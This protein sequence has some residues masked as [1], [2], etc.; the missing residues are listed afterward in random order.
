MRFLRSS[1]SGVDGPAPR[2]LGAAWLAGLVLGLGAEWLARPALSL[3]GAA[4]DLT[5]GWTLITCGLVG[6]WRSPRSRV[7]LLLA[8]S[9]FAWFL[10]TLSGSQTRA[11]AAL[12]SALLL[13]HRGPLW[14]AIIGYPS[15]RPGHRL[16]MI[17]VVA[18]YIYA[19]G[20]PAARGDVVTIVVAAAVLAATT[21]GWVMAAG[22]DRRARVTAV[23]AAAALAVP[24]AGGSAWRLMGARPGAD[25]SLL[26]WGYEAAVV[27]I[28]VGFLVELS[29]GRRAQ[30]AVTKLVV[31]L[32]ADTGTGTLR[33]RLAHALG[34]GSLVIVYW[35]PEVSGYVDERGNLVEL[36]EPGSG[37]TVTVVER[38]GEQIAALVHDVAVLDDPALV[39]SVAAAARIALSNVRLRAEVQR[40]VAELDA[41][42]RRIVEAGDAQRRRFQQQLRAGTGQ[43]LAAVGEVL[44]R[45]AWEACT[46]RDRA[47]ADG[48]ISVRNELE[49]A[50]DELRELAAGIH[51]ALLTERGLGAAL[52]SL[53]GRS[54]V[55][56]RLD[57]PSERLPVVI[58]TAIYFA[59]SE[60]LANVA[61]HAQATRVDVVVRIDGDL[62]ILVIADDGTGGADP[63]AGSGLNG[64]ADRVEALGGRL[65]VHGLAGKGSRV[66]AEIPAAPAGAGGLDA[67]CVSGPELAVHVPVFRQG[68]T[69]RLVGIG[70]GPAFLNVSVSRYTLQM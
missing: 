21:R 58:E 49:V 53:A 22:P 13:V 50:Q 2:L 32:G 28:A 43:H 55:P 57:A 24:L 8:V 36:P 60:A 35:L 38:D 33:A 47:A 59:C 12:G 40:R 5:V 70:P 34:D 69:T 52:A 44:D 10:G 7:G 25:H 4:A 26:L 18:G 46:F 19:A 45:A 15:G 16:G 14:H 11:V 27:L 20:V 66:L 65:E 68:L 9:G 64:V 3:V 30:A 37:K 62:V 51:P 29:R 6:W 23:V 54:P 1:L 42:R 31:D 67:V 39:D 61:K 48:L 17:V 56:V 63:S 41:S